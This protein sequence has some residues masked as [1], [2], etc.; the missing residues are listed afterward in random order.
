[1]VAK[2]LIEAARLSIGLQAYKVASA[3]NIA[4]H[5]SRGET[6]NMDFLCVEEIGAVWPESMNDFYL[7]QELPEW[8]IFKE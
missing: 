2:L 6:T 5:P 8:T 7:F 4:D 1:M 3:A